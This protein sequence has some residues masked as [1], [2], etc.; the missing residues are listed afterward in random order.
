MMSFYMITIIFLGTFILLAIYRNYNRVKD[1]KPRRYNL[2]VVFKKNYYVDITKNEK[3]LELGPVKKYGKNSFVCKVYL[4]D[5][6]LRDYLVKLLKID[7]SK[8][9]VT[10]KRW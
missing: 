7:Y 2:V 6:E 5:Y 10:P 3:I 1:E 9:F 4:N 8:I